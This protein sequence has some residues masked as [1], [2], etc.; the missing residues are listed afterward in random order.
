MACELFFKKKYQGMRIGC[1]LRQ[2]V[3]LIIR[4]SALTA[5]H[6][7]SRMPERIL[8][9]PGAKIILSALYYHSSTYE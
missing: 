4:L 8:D 2:G 7:A 5:S 1:L 9:T 3:N 6:N